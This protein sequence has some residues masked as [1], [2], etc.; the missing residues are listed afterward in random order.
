M[1]R[2]SWMIAIGLLLFTTA[3]LLAGDHKKCTMSTQDC[4]DHM[5]AQ[6]KSSGWVGLEL[7]RDDDSG[8]LTVLKVVPGS[9]AEAAG[10]Q[11]K[12][13]LFALN[14]VRIT[15]DNDEALM[16]ARKEWQPGQS[17]TYT[18]K[19][20]GTDRQVTLTL[21]PMPADV[22]ARYIGEHMMEHANSEM[23]KK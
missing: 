11:P 9:P 17:V 1:L 5:A 22:L 16:K 13:V 15:K 21:A 18:I 3:I 20:D 23:A 6:M 4:L 19:R 10:I 14:G 12:D 8:S 2:R 7:D